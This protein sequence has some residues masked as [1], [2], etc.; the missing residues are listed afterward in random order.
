[1]HEVLKC[2][3]TRNEP[4]HATTF[5]AH[6]HLAID[7]QHAVHEVARQRMRAARVPMLE[8]ARRL[9]QHIHTRQC[10]YHQT[11]VGRNG[12]TRHIVVR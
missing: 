1:M 11:V 7:R 2:Q 8:L 6:P 4:H 3:L 10:A 12:K 9:V 5:R